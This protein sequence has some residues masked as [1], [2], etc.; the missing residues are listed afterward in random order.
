MPALAI[1]TDQSMVSII[2][3]DA[4]MY[5][6]RFCAQAGGVN[7]D[8]ARRSLEKITL[9][10][11]RELLKVRKP[12]HSR[13]RP[14]NAWLHVQAARQRAVTVNG[15]YS[16]TEIF[17]IDGPVNSVTTHARMKLLDVTGE[18]QAT[19]HVGIVDFA[20]DRGRIHLNA[21]GEIG[22][23]NL[24]LTAPRFE[25]ALD[26]TAEVAVR[27]LLPPECESPFEAIVDRFDLFVCRADIA[28]HIHRR[29]RD[30]LVVFAYGH[31]DPAIRLVSHGVLVIDST[32]QLPATRIQQ[33]I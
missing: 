26:A 17:N 9:T 24:K 13:E 23:I 28:P 15:S 3:S 6:V 32:D 16:Y 25:G 5:E 20:G 33:G 21:D 27:M 10:R 14:T 8:D 11:R 18:V 7:E 31:G 30:G 12:Q 19:A 29:D 4:D 22:E 2:G 1:E